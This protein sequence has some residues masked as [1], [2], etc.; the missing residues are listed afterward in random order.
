MKVKV[1]GPDGKTYRV[2]VPEGSDPEAT[3]EQFGRDMG[4]NKGPESNELLNTLRIAGT[5]AIQGATDVANIPSS[6]AALSGDTAQGLNKMQADVSKMRGSDT[7]APPLDFGLGS[8]SPM[9][10]FLRPKQEKIEPES[11]RAQKLGQELSKTLDVRPGI[12]SLGLPTD[13]KKEAERLGVEMG[14]WRKALSSGTR[15]A[16]GMLL[17]GGGLPMSL[18]SGAGAAIGEAVG[19]ETGA[20]AGSIAGPVGASKFFTGRAMK[21]ARDAAP[22]VPEKATEARKAYKAAEAEGVVFSREGLEEAKNNI[23][24]LL[25][26]RPFDPDA[27]PQAALAKKKIEEMAAGEPLTWAEFQLKRDVV[28]DLGVGAKPKDA[29]LVREMTRTLDEFVRKAKPTDSISGNVPA[30]QAA[31]ADA[32]KLWGAMRRGE[33][34]EK[35]IDNAKTR[36]SSLDLALRNEFAAFV[37]SKEFKSFP[38]AEQDAI[39]EM[40]EPTGL[41]KAMRAIG[42]LP[43]ITLPIYKREFERAA[44]QRALTKS[45]KIAEMILR[46]APVEMPERAR[47]LLSKALLNSPAAA[48]LRD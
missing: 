30:A 14:P 11:T 36:G 21:S 19:G 18:I 48:A 2:E 38:K 33:K 8:G 1:T 42:Y 23:D 10:A 45:E 27:H 32:D 20:L 6:V 43:Q 15:A 39:R 25:K 46:G 47:E 13:P 17:T 29:D 34:V 44:G 7:T 26:T 40:V 4:W 22:T 31:Q 41:R 9:G 16:T 5:G 37:R 3:V 28:R 35:I 12:E 24:K